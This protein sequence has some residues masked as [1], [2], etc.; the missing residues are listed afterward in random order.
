[1]VTQLLPTGGVKLNIDYGANPPSDTTKLWVP[2]ATKPSAVECS[3]ALTF[4][5][6][7]ISLENWMLPSDVAFYPNPIAYGG[8]LYLVG[9]GQ[10]QYYSIEFAFGSLPCTTKKHS[11]W[12]VSFFLITGGHMKL[13]FL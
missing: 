8:Y 6:N 7:T 5:G 4:G 9:G 1:M 3:P 13:V 12:G 2:L 10:R 11:I